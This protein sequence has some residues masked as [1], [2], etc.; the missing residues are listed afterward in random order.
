MVQ[1]KQEVCVY[2]QT[3]KITKVTMN[4]IETWQQAKPN[5]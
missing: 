1:Q 4:N 2:D 3:G 5:H